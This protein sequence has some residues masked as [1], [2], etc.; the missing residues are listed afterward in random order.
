MVALLVKKLHVF[1]ESEVSLLFPQ[2]PAWDPPYMHILSRNMGHW[3]NELD[4]YHLLQMM[5]ILFSKERTAS[6]SVFTESYSYHR[7]FIQLVTLMF[8][9]S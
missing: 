8:D 6:H 7:Y 2:D 1:M 5:L 3:T 4:L 9:G